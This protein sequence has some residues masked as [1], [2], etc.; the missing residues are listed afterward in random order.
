MLGESNYY[1]VVLERSWSTLSANPFNSASAVLTHSE[2]TV[3]CTKV[4]CLDDILL[5]TRGMLSCQIRGAAQSAAKGI[6]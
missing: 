1:F 4:S 3:I 2:H 6:C 5:L